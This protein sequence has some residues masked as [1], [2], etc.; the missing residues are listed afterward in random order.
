[1]AKHKDIRAWIVIPDMQVP[2]HDKR[3]LKAVEKFMSAHRWDGYLNIGD[4]MDFDQISSFNANKLRLLEGRNILKDYE[5]GNR[6]LDRH[7]EIVRKNNKHA[8]FVLIEGNHEYRIERYLDV[9]PQFTGMLEVENALRLKE[10]GFKWVRNWS[11]GDLY[12]I[13]KACFAHGQYTNQYH[14][15][16]M[17]DTYGDNIFYGHTHDVQSFSRVVR[18]RNKTQ[19]GQSLGCLCNYELSYIEKNPSNWQQAFAVFYFLP[20]GL[21]SYYIPRIFNHTFVGPDGVTYSG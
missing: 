6:I 4:F 20:N 5:V 18:G 1:M 12:R 13:G 16:K 11:K 17:V 19:V 3:S 15:K 10:R 21:F 8:E 14:S 9:N 2:F 7:Q